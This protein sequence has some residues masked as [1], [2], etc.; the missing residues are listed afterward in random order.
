MFDVEKIREVREKNTQT[1]FRIS[2]LLSMEPSS[3]LC[4]FN[5]FNVCGTQHSSINIA[6]LIQTRQSKTTFQ[7]LTICF[8]TNFEMNNISMIVDLRQIW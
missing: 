5:L 8:Q 2:M 4:Q 6:V 1:T 7:N 3:T